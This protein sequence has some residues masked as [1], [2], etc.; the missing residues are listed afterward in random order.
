M[1]FI[2]A[3]D[4][5]EGGIIPEEVIGIVKWE[6]YSNNSTTTWACWEIWTLKDGNQSILIVNKTTVGFQVKCWHILQDWSC[7]YLSHVNWEKSQ[8]PLFAFHELIPQ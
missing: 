5:I 4:A 7:G 1:S 6:V 3:S 8:C 2:K